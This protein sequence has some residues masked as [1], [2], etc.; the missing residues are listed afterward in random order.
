MHTG[1]AHAGTHLEIDLGAICANWRALAGRLGRGAFDVTDAPHAV[2]GGF[3]PL[4]GD[5]IP[6]DMLAGQAGTIGYEILT[7]LGRR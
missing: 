5:G 6:V 2:E 1:P 4:I 7:A 3:L